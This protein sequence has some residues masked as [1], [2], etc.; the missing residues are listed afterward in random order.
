MLNSVVFFCCFGAV[1]LIHRDVYKRQAPGGGAVSA[2]TGAQ[3][4]ALVSMVCELTIP[5]EKMCIRD[6]TNGYEIIRGHLKQ[7]MKGMAR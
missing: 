7:V 3:G 1:P 4:A 2:L 5:K 6:S